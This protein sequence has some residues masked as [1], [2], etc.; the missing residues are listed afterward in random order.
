MKSAAAPA[1]A[2][3]Y[4]RCLRLRSKGR[5]ARGAAACAMRRSARQRLQ[6]G[7]GI[8]AWQQVRRRGD[9]EAGAAQRW[10]RQI[11]GGA[12][13][14]RRRSDELR[15]RQYAMEAARDTR[16]R[17]VAARYGIPARGVRKR[18]TRSGRTAACMQRVS[19]KPRCAR[20]AVNE[21][22]ETAKRVVKMRAVT[23]QQKRGEIMR[24]T[25]IRHA[26][27]AAERSVRTARQQ[28][29]ARA[30]G[31]AR[32]AA[33]QYFHNTTH[34]HTHTII[35]ILH[36]HTHNNNTYTHINTHTHTH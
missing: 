32:G 27:G 6:A 35:I 24:A 3:A 23:A 5:Q 13:S 4:A 33:T 20:E 16:Q 9:S 15:A 8:K 28:C 17:S 7:G 26:N 34:T 21:R 11:C 12:I 18:A 1:C 25:A 2:P 36:T 22:R 29:A 14:A 19:A 31:S 10:R 30:S